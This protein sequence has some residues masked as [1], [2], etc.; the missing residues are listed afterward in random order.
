MAAITEAGPR[1][2]AFS[3]RRVRIP[4][5]LRYV[6]LIALGILYAMPF[7]WMVSISLKPFPDLDRIPPLLLPSRLAFENYPTALFQPMIFF[8]QF[9]V[10]TIYYVGLSAL[11]QLLSSA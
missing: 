10:N 9:F 5:I 2:S 11:G 6:A 4:T 7:I 1:E 8:P 3:L